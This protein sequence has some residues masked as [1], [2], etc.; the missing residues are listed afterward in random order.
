MLA[1]FLW[2]LSGV[3]ISCYHEKEKALKKLFLALLV[4][5]LSSSLL[6][7][8][9]PSNIDK[10]T[11][12]LGKEAVQITESYLSGKTSASDAYR[13]IDSICNQLNAYIPT[14]SSSHSYITGPVDSIR[15]EFWISYL[16]NKPID[17]ARIK[18]HLS[19]LKRNL[20]G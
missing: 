12:E 6:V 11:Y 14:N 13:K 1:L 16:N 10:K 9:R 17:D 19:R 15:F 8:C 20:R 2:G 7:G 18:D 3:L 4:V 5:C